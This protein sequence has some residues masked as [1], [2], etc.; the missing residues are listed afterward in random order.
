MDKETKD[1]IKLIAGIQVEALTNLRKELDFT[2]QDL[3]RKLLQINDEEILE[4]LDNHIGLYKA[5]EE[6]P[7][8]VKTL[9]EYQLFTCSHILFRMEDEWMATNSQGI[10][11]A[12]AIIQASNRKFHP[13]L[14]LLKF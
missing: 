2:D 6:T 7:A 13:E 1:I 12:W 9:D 5:M 10:L 14:T 11:G 8:L 4:V 3:L